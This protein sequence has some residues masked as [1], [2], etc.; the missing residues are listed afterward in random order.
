MLPLPF[1]TLAM[2]PAS[3]SIRRRICLVA[4]VPYAFNMFMVDHVDALAQHYDVTILTN[5]DETDL[6]P[7]LRA[8]ARFVRLNITRPIA[9]FSDLRTLT[10]LCL[11][12]RKAR[13]DA[14][15]SMTPKAGLLATIAGRLVGVPVR[16]HW[17][18]GQ[19]WATKRGVT[20]RVLRQLDC[21]LARCATHLL[22]DCDSQRA[23][24]AAQGV[25]PAA[26]IE[27]LGNG[28]ICGV[29]GD[30]FRPDPATR[31]RVRGELGIPENAT[32]V[33]FVGRLNRDKGIPELAEA[34]ARVAQCD[35]SLH[36]VLAGPDEGGMRDATRVT[37]QSVATRTT[38]TGMTRCPEEFMAA[39][40]IFVLPSHR[41]GF[42]MSVLEAAASGVP[43]IGTAIYGL[44]DAIVDG[45]TGILVPVGDVA[46]LTAAIAMLSV[47]RARCAQLG[48]AA[49]VRALRDFS[50]E[51][52]REAF[53]AFYRRAL[54]DA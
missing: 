3:P 47:D 41:E 39:A 21:V 34:F 1:G 50:R 15:H 45:E 20:R 13:F 42:G 25:A 38:F 44:T 18:G 5:G 48:R 24:L 16:V 14:V 52:V 4:T 49:R 28:S 10:T 23:F 46:A 36:L 30:R 29:D 40:D 51:H 53:L 8:R 12:F 35:P 22:T 31:A 27:V 19:V 7:A 54:S 11:Y 9:P 43:S 37:L 2:K 32:V 26:R 33:L 17:F 6:Y